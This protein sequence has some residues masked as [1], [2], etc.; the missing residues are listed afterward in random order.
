MLRVAKAVLMIAASMISVPLAPVGAA[1]PNVTRQGRNA[2]PDNQSRN[3]WHE[4]VSPTSNGGGRSAATSV[5]DS[6]TAAAFQLAA[7]KIAN[8]SQ[9]N[10]HL[11]RGSSVVSLAVR[12]TGALA[13]VWLTAPLRRTC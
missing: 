10:Y 9:R 8:E 12:T 13:Q 7:R 6:R 5:K 11:R 3:A 1:T 2:I 4:G